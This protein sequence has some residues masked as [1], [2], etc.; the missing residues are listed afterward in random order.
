[1]EGRV[2][3]QK[4]PPIGY[5]PAQVLIYFIKLKLGFIFINAETEDILFRLT[6]RLRKK[7]VFYECDKFGC[8]QKRGPMEGPTEFPKI[9]DKTEKKRADGKLIRSLLM[10]NNYAVPGPSP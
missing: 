7:L 5:A 1:L 8:G 2:D 4:T 9:K 3:L 10:F 6:K